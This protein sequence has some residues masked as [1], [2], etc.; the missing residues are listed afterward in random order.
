MRLYLAVAIAGMFAGLPIRADASG[1]QGEVNIYSYRQAE[2]IAPLLEEFTAETGIRT[3]ILFLK[4]GLIDRVKAEGRNS[5]VDVILTVSIGRLDNARRAGITRQVEN[6]KINANIPAQ[7]RDK[8]NNW[9]ALTTRARVIYASKERVAQDTITYEELAD[10]KWKGKI[11]S[12]S[13]QHIYNIALFASMIANKGE[14]FTEKWLAGLK[15]NLARKPA[16]NDRSQARGIFS[17]ACDLGIGHA[18]YVGLMQTNDKKPQ[19]KE[20]AKS[21]KV[22]F[23]NSEGRGTHVNVSGMAMAKYAPNSQNAL[24]LMEFLSSAKAQELY[25][26]RVFEYPVKPGTKISDIVKSFGKF[27]PDTLSLEEIAKNRKAASRLVDKI[28]FNDGPNS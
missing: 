17:G 20:W 11:C 9:F 12:R 3:N 14:Q 6:P 10:P 1:D 27:K 8:Q 7:Y 28:G 22:L 15:N 24:K 18:Y 13:G 16:G 21:I 23:P 5:P 26:E 4:K 2:L 25:A 19:Q